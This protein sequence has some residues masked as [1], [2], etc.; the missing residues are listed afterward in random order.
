MG[1]PGKVLLLEGILDVIKRNQLLN[2]VEKTGN[3]LKEGLLQF[4]NEFPELIH[5]VRGRGTFLAM[6]CPKPKIRDDLVNRLKVK[7]M[8]I[9]M[10]K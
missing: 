6:S 1:D 7:G 9:L 5:S 2:V 10:E 8:S 4:Q 3:K